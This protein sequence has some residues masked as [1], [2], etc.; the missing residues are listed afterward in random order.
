MNDH[1]RRSILV[2]MR[3][4]HSRMCD[5]EA[6][7]HEAEVDSA[8]RAYTPDLSPVEKQ[9]VRGHFA[10]FRQAMLTWLEE[11]Q[12]PLARQPTS[13]RW[14]LQCGLTF[15]QV[16]AA[17]MAPRRLGGYGPLS[18]EDFERLGRM[19]DDLQ[20][21]IAAALASVRLPALAEEESGLAQAGPLGEALGL[22]HEVALRHGLIELLPRLRSLASKAGSPDYE[23]AFFGRVSSGKSSLLNRLTGQDALPVGVTPVTS[24]PVRLRHGSATAVK[25]RTAGMPSRE[26]PL[27]DLPLFVTEQGNPGNQKHVTGVDVLLP[28]P[29]LAEGVC[30]V[31]TPGVGSLARHGGEEA[32][33]YLP[34]CDLGVVLIDAGSTLSPED[35]GLLH[36]LAE[37]GIPAQVLLS[38]ADLLNDEDRA[39]AARYIEAQVERELGQGRA[40]YPVSSLAGQEALLEA[41]HREALAPLLARHEELARA[42]LARKVSQA[43]GV[44]LALLEARRGEAGPE[45]GVAAEARAALARADDAIRE[46][47]E[48]ARG[49]AR[50]ASGVAARAAAV[51]AE[52]LATGGGPEE[53]ARRIEGALLDE[54]GRARLA[55]EALSRELQDSLARV[56]RA[57]PLL[58]VDPAQVTGG[59]MRGMPV[60]DLAPVSGALK[61][62]RPG[63][64]SALPFLAAW[65]ASRRLERACG[66][67]LR[68]RVEV[69]LQQLRAWE[70]SQ[71][72][73]LAERFEH[74]AE[75]ARGLLM[76]RAGGE[77]EG[78]APQGL[79]Q[80]LRR[81]AEMRE[82]RLGVEA[83]RKSQGE[84][85]PVKG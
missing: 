44:M 39:R 14:A 68:E 72:Q 20:R 59:E 67:A 38:K 6:H 34:S 1:H 11:M 75:P 26:V 58:G 71:V 53:A 61:Q 50:G 21:L 19:Q 63:W 77:E 2:G 51:A 42:S 10:R 17:E 81:L 37:G 36:A 66:P 18:P 5:L 29:R 60:P 15:L 45:A 70:E 23:V 4:L 65:E 28:S 24:V 3:D 49:R 43:R 79:Q 13:L 9:V 35:L 85:W 82:M 41:W 74:Q 80:D 73:A 12:V 83:G 32:Y 40:V 30:F 64:L 7:I 46:A 25:V 52:A 31:D 54:A 8:F 48:A 16:A 62:A 27:G 22:L 56:A 76:R 69:Y 78:G 47:R 57:L 33:A 84:E 55:A